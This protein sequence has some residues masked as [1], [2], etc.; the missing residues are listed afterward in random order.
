MASKRW[1]RGWLNEVRALV[2]SVEILFQATVLRSHT[3][4]FEVQKEQLEQEGAAEKARKEVPLPIFV[5]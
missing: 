3:S 2:V 4:V 1:R 5:G